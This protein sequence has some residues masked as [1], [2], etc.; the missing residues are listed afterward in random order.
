MREKGSYH[1]LNI[2]SVILCDLQDLDME[3]PDSFSS[4]LN[5]LFQ[6]VFFKDKTES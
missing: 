2:S 5:Q 3:T 4:L 6:M 1:I